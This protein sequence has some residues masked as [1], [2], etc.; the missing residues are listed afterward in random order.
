MMDATTRQRSDAELDRDWQPNGRRPQST[1]ARHFSV[2]LDNL[3]DIDN[4]IIDLDAAVDQKYVTNTAA[5]FCRVEVEIRA[6]EEL[7]GG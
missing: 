2:A 5:L 3:F 6:R 7:L 4:R 1:M